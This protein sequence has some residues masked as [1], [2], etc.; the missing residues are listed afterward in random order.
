[1]INSNNMK[2]YGEVEVKLQAIHVPA[3]FVMNKQE[4]YLLRRPQSRS[5]RVTKKKRI[6]FFARNQNLIPMPYTVYY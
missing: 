2:T 1:M 6:I 3:T 5:E 4:L